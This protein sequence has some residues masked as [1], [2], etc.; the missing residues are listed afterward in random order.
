M[1]IQGNRAYLT[2][3]EQKD[4]GYS[5]PIDI[6]S[7]D[8]HEER[9]A[10]DTE[11]DRLTDL[12]NRD[13]HELSSDERAAVPQQLARALTKSGIIRNI[14]KE[15]ARRTGTASLIQGAEALLKDNLTE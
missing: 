9:L 2:I 3:P 5:S 15:S 14:A 11:V 7:F 8:I 12:S 13:P 1:D 4:S 10:T 6:E